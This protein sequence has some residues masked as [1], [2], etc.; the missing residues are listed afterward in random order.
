MITYRGN[1]WYK[2]D[3][4]LHTPASGC[5]KNRNVT[6]K[7][8]MEKVK[9]EKLDCIA[10]TDHNTTE[11]IDNIKEAA[12]GYEVIVFPGVEITCTENKIHLLA[13][14][15]PE[16][17]VLDIQLFLHDLGIELE[18]Y[19][20]ET[21]YVKKSIDEI[22]KIS[23]KSD[24]ILI[25]AHVDDYNGLSQISIPA[26]KDILALDEI[27]AVQMVNKDLALSIISS[28][29]AKKVG[30]L[31]N[32]QD[33]Y[34][35]CSNLIKESQKG[36]VT[37][38]DNPDSEGEPRHGLWGIGRQYTFIKMGEK[39]NLQGLRQALLF[40]KERIINIFQNT[41][42]NNIL[43]STWIKKIIINDLEIASDLEVNFNPYLNTIIGGRGSGKSTIIKLLTGVFGY[44][45]F[46]DLQEIYDDFK[47]FY[48]IKNDNDEGVLKESTKII[49]ELFKNNNKYRITVN[50]FKYNGKSKSIIEKFNHTNETY[51][52]IEGA[53]VNDI[54]KV[55]IYNQKQIYSLSRKPN[56]LR[57]KMDVL[58]DNIED[59]KEKIENYISEYKRQYLLICDKK[60][61]ILGK[62]KIELEL[63]DIEEKIDCF[64]ESNISEVLKEYEIFNKEK[65]LL[66]TEIRDIN[67]KIEEVKRF[68]EN[69][70]GNK[71][72]IEIQ[73]EFNDE[74]QKIILAKRKE[75]L[76][77]KS[78]I[79]N[80]VLKLENIKEDYIRE[81]KGSN[82]NSRLKEIK[83]KY[84]TSLKIL[85]KKGIN[86]NEI[87]KL[88]LKKETKQL[89]LQNLIEIESTI[90]KEEE[91]L[92]N[93]K[94]DYVESRKNITNLR[95]KRIRE[96]LSDKDIYID[97]KMF[98]DIDDF[99][100]KFRK[101]IQ[102]QTRYNKDIED[103]ADMCFDG[104][105]TKNI[106]KLVGAIEK[107]KSG[108]DDELSCGTKFKNVLRNLNNEQMAELNI[109]LPEDDIEIKY[110]SNN[111]EYKSLKNAS[112]GQRTSAILTFILLQG[113]TPLILDQP[114]D[115][116]DNHVIQDLVVKRLREC[117][118]ERQIIVVTHNANVPVNGDA[119][120]VIA[121]DSESKKI[122]IQ[123]VGTIEEKD[124]KKEICE[125]MEGGE[126]AFKMRAKRYFDN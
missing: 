46:Q 79:N 35:K 51:E 113:N 111:N 114:E 124:I 56:E 94:K 125:V 12:K 122:K 102:K 70:R 45:D 118:K 64:R 38:S 8:F 42:E 53:K 44:E 47:R 34:E 82:W 73:D 29:K 104:D 17:N 78:D 75:I 32:K 28:K 103:I 91:V 9:A 110:R 24:V 54:F 106:S 92:E 39:P 13:I 69:F 16:C 67:K 112:A 15:D 120:L 88:L 5:F 27:R 115:D 55:D 21:I 18:Y 37:F 43:P 66:N 89:E 97:V 86:I 58:V 10:I 20:K 121:M 52:I 76:T 117:K 40:P 57:E 90:N 49:V 123:K 11:W 3:F 7:E 22:V 108:E 116:L 23:K 33:K 31:S 25:P 99:K 85:E 87:N 84:N 26:Q 61:K 101:I 77:C 83:E 41:N 36:I 126:Q 72:K 59:E 30:K 63:K 93:I 4:H 81:I 109:L 62:M 50:G 98:R 119:E 68:N 96:L 74:I 105:L 71:S 2:C 95:K 65:N 48:S 14:F 19:A 6:A 60:S 1:R 80:I 100:A 107:I